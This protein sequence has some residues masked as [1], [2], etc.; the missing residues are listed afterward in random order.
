MGGGFEIVEAATD[1]KSILLRDAAMESSCRCPVIVK[2]GGSLYDL[3]DLGRR[4]SAW[5]AELRAP[6]VVIVPGGGSAADLVRTWDRQFALGEQRA[7]WLALRALALNAHLLAS[8]IPAARVIEHLDND[9]GPNGSVLCDILDM[10]AWAGRDE[11]NND[12]HLPHTWA[13][14]SDSLAAHVAIR[15]QADRLILLKSVAIPENMDWRHAAQQGL[16]DQFFPDVIRRAPASLKVNAINF[17]AR[18]HSND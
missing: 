4:L 2:V 5:L 7:H 13:V 9:S 12:D 3:P 1:C 10:H 18:S 17:R 6:H 15:A 16:V 14:T 8:V 11:R